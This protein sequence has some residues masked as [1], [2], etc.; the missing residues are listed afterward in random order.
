MI[1]QRLFFQIRIQAVLPFDQRESI[2]GTNRKK[3]KFID[4]E[5]NNGTNMETKPLSKPYG[6]PLRKTKCNYSLQHF[7]NNFE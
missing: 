1:L 2:F 6:K 4:G 3:I 5:W 7:R